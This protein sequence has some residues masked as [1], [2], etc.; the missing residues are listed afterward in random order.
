MAGMGAFD[1]ADP[2]LLDDQLSEDERMIRDS[3]R[4]YADDKL[5]P[6]IVDAF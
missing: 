6:R 4:A 5:A 3:A 2:F 1:W